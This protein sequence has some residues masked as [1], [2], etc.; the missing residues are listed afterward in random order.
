MF[1]CNNKMLIETPREKLNN[2]IYDFSSF[3]LS[4]V[5]FKNQ[6]WQSFFLYKIQKKKH[7]KEDD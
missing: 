2:P 7:S 6:V 1:I 4:V 3:L 5:I